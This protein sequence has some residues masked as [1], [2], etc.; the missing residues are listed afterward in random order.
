LPSKLTCNSNFVLYESQ[1]F[2]WGNHHSNPL[3]S[4]QICA[5]FSS[6]NSDVPL[7]CL[8]GIQ[9]HFGISL[10]KSV[11]GKDFIKTVR[12]SSLYHSHMV[13]NSLWYMVQIRVRDLQLQKNLVREGIY[14]IG[15]LRGSWYAIDNF[16]S[17]LL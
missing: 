3:L 17:N 13:R 1:A 5:L 2:K 12:S 14:I 15:P 6:L 11:F 16:L 9:T 7:F 10:V 8:W 4:S